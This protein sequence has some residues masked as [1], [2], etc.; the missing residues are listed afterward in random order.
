MSLWGTNV[1]LCTFIERVIYKSM[2]SFLPMKSYPP[3]YTLMVPCFTEGLEF[4]SKF[5]NANLKKAIRVSRTEYELLL[6]EDYNTNGHYHWFYFKTR[7]RLPAG[8]IVHFKILNMIKPTS[9]YNSGFKPFAFSS[10]LNQTRGKLITINN[11]KELAGTQL[12]LMY[13]TIR[14]QSFAKGCLQKQ[15][16]SVSL[17][18]TTPWSGSMFIK[19][20]MMRYSS[21][22]SRPTHSLISSHIFNTFRICLPPLPFCALT[23]CARR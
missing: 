22:S 3:E 20:P 8:T 4:F 9:L 13:P 1:T 21:L 2:P 5:E 17:F 23:R 6:S 12:A 14:T 10:Q 16:R 15:R 7:A 19:L 18:I 11:I